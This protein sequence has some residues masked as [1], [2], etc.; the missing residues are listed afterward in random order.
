MIDLCVSCNECGATLEFTVLYNQMDIEVCTKP[1]EGCGEKRYWEG[2]KK[3]YED[4][5][6]DN[7]D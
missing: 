2:H 3:G 6:Y 1:C 5:E 7:T 4:G